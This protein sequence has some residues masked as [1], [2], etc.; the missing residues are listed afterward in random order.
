MIDAYLNGGGSVLFM[1]DPPPSISFKDYLAK[2]SVD[3]G[4][5]IVVDASGVGRLVGTSPVMPLVSPSRITI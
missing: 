5:N 1:L 2:W 3:V 4:D